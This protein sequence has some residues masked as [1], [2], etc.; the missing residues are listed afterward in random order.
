MSA[1]NKPGRVAAIVREATEHRS[2]IKERERIAR[3]L[4]EDAKDILREGWTRRI[5]RRFRKSVIV[6]ETTMPDGS[7]DAATAMIVPRNNFDTSSLESNLE[8]AAIE[9]K[10]G[11]YDS[12]ILPP[13]KLKFN[14]MTFGGNIK[15][16]LPSKRKL[17]QYSELLE[18]IREKIPDL[19]AMSDYRGSSLF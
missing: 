13:P 3:Q 14:I 1:E 7:G 12:L 6:L 19:I 8:E 4:R 10:V 2:G 5:D 11:D 18:I 17:E 9:I 16:S 15:F